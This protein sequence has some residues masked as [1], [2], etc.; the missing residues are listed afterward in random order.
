[1][2]K[3]RMTGISDEGDPSLAGQIALHRELG[4]QALEIRGIDGVNICEMDDESFRDAEELLQREEM[5]V[6][7]FASAIANWSRPIA[8]DFSRDRDD[9]LRA[10]PRMR[11]LGTRYIRIMSY[12]NPAEGGVDEA[13][14]GR[15]ALKRVRELTRI[16][17]GEG[18]VLV[19]ENCDGWASRRPEN[20]ARMLDEIPDPALQIVF[21]PG[22]PVSHGLDPD[23]VWEFYRACGERLAHFHIKDCYRDA[24]GRI[25]HCYPGEGECALAE[26]ISDLDQRGYAGWFSIEPHMQAVP[27]HETADPEA[28]RR[29]YREYMERAEQLVGELIP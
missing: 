26:L 27:G 23:S 4:W 25:V 3:Q 1:M 21:D 15:E 6:V 24:E 22:N 7:A 17:A 9:L 11:R 10:A 5:S 29:I 18:V 2:I 20:L 12:A 19:H 13:E 8:G 14:W 28:A 16:A